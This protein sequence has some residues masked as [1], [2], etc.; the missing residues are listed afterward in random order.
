MR[1]S[2]QDISIFDYIS[3]RA[4]A[5]AGAGAGAEAGSEEL[6]QEPG[7]ELEQDPGLELE[8]NLALALDYG[9]CLG[10][11]HRHQRLGQGCTNWAR[12]EV[13]GRHIGCG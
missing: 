12:V 2:G 6:E 5:G 11:G 7:P 3:P 9:P 8:F 4:G 13:L 1:R 10:F